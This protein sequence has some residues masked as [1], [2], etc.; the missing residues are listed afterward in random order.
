MRL[1]L[2]SN[3]TNAGEEYLSYT[4]PYINNFLTEKEKQAIFIPYAG[5]VP[6]FDNYE[7][8][9][10]EKFEAIG[11]R[12]E[13]LHRLKRKIEAI[14]NAKCIVIGGGNTFHLLKSLQEYKLIEVIRNRI[15]QGIPYIGWSAGS[16][17]ACPTI[18]TTNDMPIV[19]PE[20]FNALGLIP[21]Q[22][23]PHYTDFSDENHAGETREMRI[24]EFLL[25][26]RKVYVAGL[27]EGTLFHIDNKSIKLLGNK[28]CRIFKYDQKPQEV[29][30]GD[31]L[32]F[33]M[34]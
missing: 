22:I 13:A 24:E 1:L 7:K 26:N 21:F 2:F 10:A 17:M 5:I 6:G 12:I 28:F 25:V 4:L 3:S 16:N 33:L 34:Q 32:S 23:N 18:R 31:N 9:V 19:E 15:L 8:M 20:D 11:I 27:R 29:N 14:Q 30:S